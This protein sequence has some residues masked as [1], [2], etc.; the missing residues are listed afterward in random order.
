MSAFNRFRLRV[1]IGT[2]AVALTMA[3]GCR[4]TDAV[5]SVDRVPSAELV[6]PTKAIIPLGFRLRP[7]SSERLNV[8]KSSEGW[9]P[10][11]YNDVARY[12]SIGYGHLIKKAPCDGSEPRE[13]LHR[14]SEQ[15]GE[16]LLFSDM[17]S[18][19]YTVMT[20]VQVD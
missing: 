3:G 14:I 11:R 20:A 15:K 9:Y 1:A 12:C 8:T 17:A 19:R 10:Y 18:S 5:P 13:F 16:E 6:S 4:S 7:I 2:T